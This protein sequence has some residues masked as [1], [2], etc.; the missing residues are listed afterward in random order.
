LADLT[1]RERAS[2]LDARQAGDRAMSLL[3]GEAELAQAMIA[4][5]C[6][7]SLAARAPWAVFVMSPLF[8]LVAALAVNSILM[9]RLLSPLQGLTPDEMPGSY[10]ALIDVAGVLINYVLGAVLSVGCIVVALRQRL[11]SG[12]VWLGVGLIAVLT[13]LLGF[14]MHVFPA[15]PAHKGAVVYSVADVVYWHDRASL[16]ASLGVSALRAVVLF[17][18]AGMAY[19][20]VRLRLTGRMGIK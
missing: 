18:M 15:A 1:E 16:A 17:S 5:G 6:G 9:F 2:G 4:K 14:H 8:L 12:W 10:R 13:G 7:R 20:M 11:E 3:G 19:R